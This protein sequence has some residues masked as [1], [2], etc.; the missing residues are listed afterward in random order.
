MQE[1]GLPLDRKEPL[2]DE[3]VVSIVHVDPNTGSFFCSSIFLF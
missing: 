1:A 3:V 2:E